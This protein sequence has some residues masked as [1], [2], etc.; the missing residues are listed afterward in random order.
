MSD[1]AAATPKR[2]GRPRGSRPARQAPMV[3]IDQVQLS[4]AMKRLPNDSWRAAAYAR[5]Y[6]ADNTEACRLAGFADKSRG[7]LNVTAHRLFHDPRMLLALKELGEKH[8]VAG[9]PDALRAIDEIVADR[10]HPDRLKAAKM[11]ID[12]AY[13][14]QTTHRVEVEHK[15]VAVPD[16]AALTETLNTIALRFGLDQQKVI[17]RPQVI[18]AEYEAVS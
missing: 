12:R 11:R 5:F 14:L 1:A 17:S 2:R 10:E 16:E 4:D 18:D 8:L 15:H 9:I 6:V 3:P 7:S 13:P